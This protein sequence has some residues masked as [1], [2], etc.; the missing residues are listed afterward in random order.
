MVFLTQNIDFGGFVKKWV[1]EP[2]STRA[3]GW[4]GGGATF[5]PP[6]SPSLGVC[7]EALIHDRERS[8]S[9]IFGASTLTRYSFRSLGEYQFLSF[10][11]GDEDSGSKFGFPVHK[12]DGDFEPGSGSVASGRVGIVRYDALPYFGIQARNSQF[13]QATSILSPRSTPVREARGFSCLGQF[14]TCSTFSLVFLRKTPLAA[15][16]TRP[17]GFLISWGCSALVGSQNLRGSLSPMKILVIKV[18]V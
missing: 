3:R 1:I 14:P 9:Q 5:S 12:S 11:N 4:V 16:H 18:F 2:S 10:Y 17:R 13:R 15:V 8:P 6:G 7:A